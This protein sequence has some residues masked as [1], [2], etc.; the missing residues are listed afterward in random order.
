MIGF[1]LNVINLLNQIGVQGGIAAAN[2]YDQSLTCIYIRPFQIEFKKRL[3]FKC[4][5]Y[6]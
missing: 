4:N 2:Y 5:Y 1:S 3:N 6:E